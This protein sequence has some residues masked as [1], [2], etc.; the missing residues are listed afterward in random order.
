MWD[1]IGQTPA[2]I[3]AGLVR[4]LRSCQKVHFITV[5]RQDS[6]VADRPTGQVTCQVAYHVTGTTAVA[7]WALDEYVPVHGL[8]PIKPL[9]PFNYPVE[10]VHAA[11][12][13]EFASLQHTLYTQ[14]E[15]PTIR[16]SKLKNVH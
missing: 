4:S 14:H 12:Q 16:V 1:R 5:E 10:K 11:T 9:L 7:W 3:T 6:R 8:Q 15:L 2:T 13:L